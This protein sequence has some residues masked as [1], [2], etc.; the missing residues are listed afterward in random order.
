[1]GECFLYSNNGEAITLKREISDGKTLVANAITAKG[2]TTATTASFQIMA[3]NIASISTGIE[4]KT[5][6]T[7]N[8]ISS[9]YIFNDYI[10]TD[11]SAYYDVDLPPGVIYISLNWSAYNGSSSKSGT[12]DFNPNTL[13]YTL[14]SN[15]KWSLDSDIT[16]VASGNSS[17]SGIK[18]H[19]VLYNCSILSNGKLRITVSCI[20]ESGSFIWFYFQINKLSVICYQ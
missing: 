4:G 9:K 15:N 18:Y 11:S 14:T 2:V 20:N 7:K 6:G 3:N 19:T 10:T 16:C 12:N 13:Y 17:G 5:I 8:L 1:M